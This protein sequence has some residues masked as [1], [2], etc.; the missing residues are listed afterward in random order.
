MVELK[1]ADVKTTVV[2]MPMEAPLRWALG[3]VR[4]ITRTIVEVSTD[5]GIVGLGETTGAYSKELI[6]NEIK[7]AIV[8]C[9]PFNLEQIVAKSVWYPEKTFFGRWEADLTSFAGIEMALWDIMGKAIGR[10]VCDLLG[11]TRRTRVAFA[12]YIM[13][14]YLGQ[15]KTG[16]E[17][18]PQQIA[19]FCSEVIQKE[20]FK[21]L[22]IKLGIFSPRNDIQTIKEIRD[23]VG[24][25]IELRVD[26]NSVWSPETS[27]RVI[28]AME[29]YGVKN[30]EEPTKGIDALARVR[31]LVNTPI[32]THSSLIPEILRLE[33]ADAIVGDLHHSG[34]I[35][36]ARKLASAAEICNL[37]FWLHSGG[38]LGISTAAIIHFAA[39][40]PF[41][42]H[43]NQTHYHHQVDDIVAGG[44][45]TYEKGS[46]AVP[47]GP[48]LGVELDEKKVLKYAELYNRQGPYH[49][50]CDQERPEWMPEM[51]AW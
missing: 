11:G 21:T 5:A 36:R 4:G 12:A 30:V 42:I 19:K 51:P 34:G 50:Y 43:A 1:I 8:N 33:A 9:D 10:P 24:E 27:I 7:P 15:A 48:G 41:I 13:P 37:D 35:L 16:G 40:M 25:D 44:K 38:E 6:D 47:K 14:R 17:S 2:N 26:P 45:L 23:V 20:G 22:E 29:K 49:Y 39:S 28:K 46:M 18:T 32:S 31:R 3:T